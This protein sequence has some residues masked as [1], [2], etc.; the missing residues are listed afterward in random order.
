MQYKCSYTVGSQKFMIFVNINLY[1]IVKTGCKLYGDCTIVS[2]LKMYDGKV[3]INI[4]KIK[5]IKIK[6]IEYTKIEP[7]HENLSV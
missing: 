7:T 4:C 3:K 2:L 1:K 5:I 6:H